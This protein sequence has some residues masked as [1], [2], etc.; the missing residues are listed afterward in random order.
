MDD[1]DAARTLA[2]CCAER[3]VAVDFEVR[4]VREHPVIAVLFT[5]G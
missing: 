4:H 3:D 2:A 5:R 1:V